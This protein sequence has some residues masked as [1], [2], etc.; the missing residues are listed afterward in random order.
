M[1]PN[2]GAFNQAL[3]NQ[4]RRNRIAKMLEKSSKKNTKSTLKRVN[5]SWNLVKNYNIKN[6]AVENR[7]GSLKGARNKAKGLRAPANGVKF[8]NNSFQAYK[9]TRT[10]KQGPFKQYPVELAKYIPQLRNESQTVMNRMTN[11]HFERMDPIEKEFME[12]AYRLPVAKA[13][14]YRWSYG[15]KEYSPEVAKMMANLTSQ[16]NTPE[17]MMIAVNGLSIS[18]SMKEKMMM[19]IAGMYR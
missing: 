14:N 5:G 6:N 11:E 15:R 13:T 8:T 2:K 19:N 17:E 10:M 16:Y 3:L 18:N 7:F 12:S 4:T 1:P 9:N